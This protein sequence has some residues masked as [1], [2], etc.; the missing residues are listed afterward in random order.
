M[1]IPD[2]QIRIPS[3]TTRLPELERM[4]GAQ[5]KAILARCLDDPTMRA[6]AKRQLLIAR[7]GWAILPAGIVAYLILSSIRVYGRII[8]L[9]L[10]TAMVSAIAIMVASVFLHHR[11]SSRRL[12]A[13]VQAA[14]EENG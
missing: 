3:L 6:L 12:R 14:T 13:L 5:R 9:I 11:W 7:I 10:V 8:C 1:V 4:P 2:M